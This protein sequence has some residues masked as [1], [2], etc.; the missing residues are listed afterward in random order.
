MPTRPED[1]LTSSAMITTGCGLQACHRTSADADRRL[2]VRLNT[3]CAHNF[4]YQ[5]Q[6]PVVGL[7]MQ[8]VVDGNIFLFQGPLCAPLM[9]ECNRSQFKLRLKDFP[10]HCHHHGRTDLPQ[11]DGCCKEWDEKPQ[12]SWCHLNHERY[13]HL[14]AK[15]PANSVVQHF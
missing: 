12:K 1:I 7:A 10:W 11:G 2:T 13:F 14:S 4:I 9:A 5:A 8:L 6:L 15:E 3:H